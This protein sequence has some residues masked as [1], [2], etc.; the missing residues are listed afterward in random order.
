MAFM[1]H[2]SRLLVR[3]STGRAVLPGARSG[4]D[5]YPNIDSTVLEDWIPIVA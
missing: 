2:R 5:W 1:L 4:T 3:P